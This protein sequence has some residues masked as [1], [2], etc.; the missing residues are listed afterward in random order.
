MRRTLRM[1]FRVEMV[2]LLMAPLS[3]RLADA[4]SESAA[5]A[6]PVPARKVLVAAK[7]Q[8][9]AIR[10]SLEEAVRAELEKRGVETILGSDVLTEAD[11]ASEEAVR[12]KVESLGVDGVIGYVPL[13]IEESVK[14]TSAHLSIGIGGYGGGGLGMFVGGSVPIGGSTTVVRT[15]HVRA[16]YFTRPFAGPAWEKVYSEK[17]EADTAKLV[18]DLA[19]DSIKALK[20]K[21]FIPAE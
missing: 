18:E 16:R 21:K 10:R 11:V 15:V 6:K 1:L 13:S 7:V 2:L 19:K 14:T 3:L 20:K 12:M 5:D 4:G 8:E 17:L 9:E